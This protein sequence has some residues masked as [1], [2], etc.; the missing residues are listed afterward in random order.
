MKRGDKVVSIGRGIRWYNHYLDEVDFCKNNGFD[1]MQIWYQNGEICINNIPDPKIEYIKTIGFPVI[2]HA[3]FDPIDFELYGNDLL[4]KVKILGMNEVI[5]HPVSKKRKV[6]ADTQSELVKQAK[7]FSAKAKKQGVTWYL[8]NNSVIDG[9]HYQP[10]DIK[11]VFEAD[12]YAEQLLDIAHI[13]NYD[14][15]K[16]IIN[17]KF[18]KC[19]HIA[20]K[21][22]DV[23]H[24]HLPLSQGDIDYG[25]VFKKYLPGFSGRVI[26]EVDGTDEEII[27][28]KNI[29][30]QAL[31]TL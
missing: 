18:P 15:L 2:I 19:L 7:L 28:S 26:L 27:L 10:E 13:D 12:D 8:E 21:H 30:E 9:F 11:R 23:P 5:I 31:H 3:V 14:H 24:E 20:G 25:F 22:F 17:V 29:I 6:T 16:E 1:F 4:E